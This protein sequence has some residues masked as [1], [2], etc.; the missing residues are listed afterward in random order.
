M[1]RGAGE[2]K[3]WRMDSW[4]IHHRRYSKKEKNKKPY[5]FPSVTFLKTSCKSTIDFFCSGF[6]CA[7][8]L[9]FCVGFSNFTVMIF[10][11]AFEVSSFSWLDALRENGRH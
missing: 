11:V 6:A 3:L 2:K 8:P 10:S 1:K 7:I 5:I 4:E 9:T